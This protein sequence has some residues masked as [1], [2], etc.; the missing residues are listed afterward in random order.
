MTPYEIAVAHDEAEDLADRIAAA[1]PELSLPGAQTGVGVAALMILIRRLI[2]AL[3]AQDQARIRAA[4]ADLIGRET[5]T[6]RGG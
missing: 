3:P 2:A 6:K 5:W 1:L 4:I